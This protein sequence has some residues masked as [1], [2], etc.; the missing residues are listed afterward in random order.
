MTNQSSQPGAVGCNEG[1]GGCAA[2]PVDLRQL[3]ERAGISMDCWDM[4]AASLAYSEGCHG[5]T[6]A[7]LEKFAGL[8]GF[9]CWNRAIEANLPAMRGLV[10]RA[11][12]SLFEKP[13]QPLPVKEIGCIAIAAQIA[14]DWDKFDSYEEAVARGVEAAHGIGAGAA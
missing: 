4:G 12:G 11:I 2:A 9:E 6:R 8:V 10:D 1:L 3:A 13:L 7:H 14:Y 5:I